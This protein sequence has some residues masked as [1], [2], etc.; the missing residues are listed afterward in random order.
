MPTKCIVHSTLRDATAPFTNGYAQAKKTN[1]LN[2]LET[3]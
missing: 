1:Y 3:K 2:R